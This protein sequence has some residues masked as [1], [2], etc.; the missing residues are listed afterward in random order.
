MEDYDTDLSPKECGYSEIL[1]LIRET[2]DED[3]RCEPSEFREELRVIIEPEDL[4][5]VARA[6]KE[7]EP[8]YFLHLSDLTA[9]DYPDR[10]EGRFDIVYQFYSFKINERIRLRLI[11]GEDESV[12]SLT[13]LWDTADWLERECYDMFGVQFDGHPNMERILMP[14]ATRSH[15]LRKDYPLE[16]RKNYQERRPE[17]AQEAEEWEIDREHHPR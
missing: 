7:T 11:I 15:P 12:P 16:P 1:D 8:F 17:V 10:E 6:L 5:S 2:V 3:R 14:K 13:P 9:V 4:L